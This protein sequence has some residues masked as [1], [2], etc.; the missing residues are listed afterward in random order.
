MGK[1]TPPDTSKSKDAKAPFKKWFTLRLN[2]AER[3]CILGFI[4]TNDI[5]KTM[6][7][8]NAK[9]FA[10]AQAIIVT[11]MITKDSRYDSL[12]NPNPLDDQTRLHS[13]QKQ[14]SEDSAASPVQFI[15]RLPV[16]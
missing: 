10:R 6:D 4:D 5:L 2:Q 15:P 1:D 14:T 7:I 11:F 13:L 9:T 12:L 8:T 3:N 16:Q